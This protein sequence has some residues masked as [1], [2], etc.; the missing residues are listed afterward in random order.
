M[1]ALSY[2]FRNRSEKIAVEERRRLGVSAYDPLS[3]DALAAAH[4]VKIVSVDELFAHDSALQEAFRQRPFWGCL[5]Q[6]PDVAPLIVLH[7]DQSPARRESTLMHEIAHFLL[8]H[9]GSSLA[10]LIAGNARNKAQEAEAAYLGGCLQLPRTAL[11]WAFQAGLSVPRVAARFGA[12][13]SMVTFR[14]RM[15][16]FQL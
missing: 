6:L 13:E 4:G 11:K 14:C 2:D 15:T 5:M 8:K 12:S 16:G 3:G 10:A 1:T 7:P 9:S